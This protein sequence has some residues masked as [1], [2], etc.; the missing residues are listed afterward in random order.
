MNAPIRILHTESSKNM[1]GQELRILLEM[2]RMR[3]LGFE[4]ILAARS[5]TPILA[6]AERRGLQTHAIP[7][8][9]R[10]DPISMVMFWRLMRGARIQ[11][12]NAHGSRDAWNAFLVARMLGIRTVRS[13]HVANPIRSH[14]LGRMIYGSLCDCVLTTSESIR[15]GLIERG[16]DADKIVS[17]PTGVDVATYAAACR[18]GVL[19]RELGIPANV[20]LIG[21]TSVLRKDKGPDIFLQACDELLSRHADAWC[22]LA[23][24]GWM[25]EELAALHA[26]L[27]QRH[28][29]ILAGYRRDIPQLLAELDIAVLAARIPEG[30]PQAILQAHAAHVPVVATEVGGIAEV[31]KAGETAFTVPPNNPA[32]LANAMQRAL[33]DRPQATA[34]AEKGY[35]MVITQYSVDAMLKRMAGLYRNLANPGQHT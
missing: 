35:V 34:Q 11:V 31:A 27:P 5:N 1:G 21:M 13:R 22:V 28:R 7:M 14:R 15:A 19:R 8:H 12:V 20:P 33:E 3:D 2:E 9:S 17:V 30:V 18:N 26:T 10:L 24:D 4:S 23:G 25:R 6:E 29:I 16:V 32:A